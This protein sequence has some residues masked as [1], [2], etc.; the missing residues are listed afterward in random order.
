MHH[1]EGALARAAT[2]WEE[3]RSGKC[4]LEGLVLDLAEGSDS[5][6]ETI[7]ATSAKRRCKL[8]DE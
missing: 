5:D 6:G 2:R 3:L 7:V 1:A 8:D 4:E